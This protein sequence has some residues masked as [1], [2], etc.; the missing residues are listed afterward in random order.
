MRTSVRIRPDHACACAGVTRSQKTQS[1]DLLRFQRIS[2][3]TA[4]GTETPHTP[5]PPT[6]RAPSRG[7]APTSGRGLRGVK[8][9]LNDSLGLGVLLLQEVYGLPQ[10]Q[11]LGVLGQKRGGRHWRGLEHP[12]RAGQRAGHR[13]PAGVARRSGLWGRSSVRGTGKEPG[14]W[15]PNREAMAGLAP[16]RAA[17]LLLGGLRQV[18]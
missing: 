11:Q 17:H 7:R 16:P 6:H 10:V 4:K 3:F 8:R 12:L 15:G 5:C 1:V 14:R 9:A 18:P 13:L 2:G